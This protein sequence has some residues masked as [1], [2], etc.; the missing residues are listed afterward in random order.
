MYSNEEQ[1]VTSDDQLSLAEE[2]FFHLPI[3]SEGFKPHFFRNQDLGNLSLTSKI[4]KGAVSRELNKRAARAL[5]TYVVLGNQ[6]KAQ[7]MI[8][9]NPQLILIKSKAVDYIGRIIEGSPFQAAIGAGDKPMWEIMLPYLEG[10][11]NGKEKALQQ[12]NEQFPKGIND[13][14]ASDL[15]PYYSKILQTRTNDM[16]AGLLLIEEFIKKITCQKTIS[17][18]KHFNMQELIAAY[19]VCFEHYRA[20][21]LNDFYDARTSFFIVISYLQRQMT[22]YDMQMHCSGLNNVLKDETSFRR[23]F[24]LSTNGRYNGKIMFPYPGFDPTNLCLNFVISSEDC[25]TAQTCLSELQLYRLANKGKGVLEQLCQRK[26]EALAQ[27]GE[28][29]KQGVD[30]SKRPLL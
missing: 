16:G 14:P 30:Y 11:E 12:F 13:V 17:Q 7:A 27:L 8:E 26:T 23:T 6:D 15:K 25:S 18:G 22:A 24:K 19:Q 10:L 2:V 29:L 28:F 3:H 21:T 5:S 1:I 20:D 4:F 9:N